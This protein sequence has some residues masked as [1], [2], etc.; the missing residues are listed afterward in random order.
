MEVRTE[1]TLDSEEYSRANRSLPTCDVPTLKRGNAL[2]MT[3]CRGINPII[4]SGG[5]RETRVLDNR[6]RPG[7]RIYAML[8]Q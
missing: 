1:D 4:A 6:A 3:P 8:M 2:S 5:I 7:L